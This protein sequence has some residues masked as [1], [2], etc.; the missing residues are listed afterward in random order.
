MGIKYWKVKDM[1][2]K[3][4]ESQRYGYRDFGIIKSEIFAIYGP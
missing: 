2:I 4:L 1:G 3:I